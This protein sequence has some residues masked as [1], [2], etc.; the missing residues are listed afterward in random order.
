METLETAY[1][2]LG[3][4]LAMRSEGAAPDW[5]S[6]EGLT[7]Y[8]VRT[9]YAALEAGT[10]GEVERAVVDGFLRAAIALRSKDKDSV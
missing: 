9:A 4:W 3:R 5:G 1:Y 10:G 6:F 2:N 8:A 7:L